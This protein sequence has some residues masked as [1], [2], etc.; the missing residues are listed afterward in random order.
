MSTRGY[1]TIV[2]DAKNILLAAFYPNSAYPSYLGVSVLDAL[3]E[4]KFPEFIEALRKDY[5]EEV[6]TVEGIQRTWY[7][8]EDANKDDYFYDYA[9]EFEPGKGQL[10]LFH[11]GEKALTVGLDDIPLYK[12]IFEHE[13]VLY[14]PLCFD[15]RTMTLNKDFYAELRKMIRAGAQKEDFLALAEKN[16]ALLYMDNGRLL[17]HTTFNRDGSFIKY[18]RDAKTDGTLKFIVDN[19]SYSGRNEYYLYVQTPFFRGSVPGKAFRSPAAAEKGIAEILR[20]RPDDVRASMRLFSEIDQFKHRITNAYRDVSKPLDERDAEAT[21]LRT[22]MMMFVEDLFSKHN[23]LG[24][25][26]NQVKSNLSDHV[27]YVYKSAKQVEEKRVEQ[28]PSLSE[29]ICSAD[30]NRTSQSAMGKDLTEIER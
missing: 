14:R 1:L 10:N 28:K 22:N 3:A 25:T 15:S 26:L 11:F 6:E 12:H 9:Y 5:P 24:I 4:G 13:D 21:G 23:L 7:V 17:D 2:D 16:N 18:V 8:K 27:S 29:Q 19:Q 20:V 30:A